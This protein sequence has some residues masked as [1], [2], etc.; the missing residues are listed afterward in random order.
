[1][2]QPNEQPLPQL[3]NVPPQGTPIPSRMTAPL[4]SQMPPAATTSEAIRGPPVPIPTARPDHS[5][6]GAHPSSSE[7]YPHENPRG[8]GRG[9]PPGTRG[10]PNGYERKIGRGTSWRRDHES[11]D[12]DDYSFRGHPHL[13]RG[14]AGD[15]EEPTFRGR[16]RG[17]FRGRRSSGSFH[18]DSGDYGR[19]PPREYERRPPPAGYPPGGD[20]YY[21]GRG[22]YPSPG[23]DLRREYPP[24]AG[25][26]GYFDD[27][28]R[29][30]PRDPSRGPPPTAIPPEDRGRFYDRGPPP[31][32]A[33]E[34]EYAHYSRVP[35]VD[36]RDDYRGPPPETARYPRDETRYPPEPP[37]TRTQ[38][39]YLDEGILLEDFN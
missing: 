22:A 29:Y 23:Y 12:R 9:H 20:P 30:D 27:Y 31:P 7:P 1:M 13:Q 38:S 19:P 34:D 32:A 4:T 5:S 37:R 3:G 16:G 25:G 21:E 35:R 15:Y 24:E 17:S 6:Q 36:P 26:R 8:R 18:R 33:R 14:R 2:S 11:M 39:G 28:A 10:H